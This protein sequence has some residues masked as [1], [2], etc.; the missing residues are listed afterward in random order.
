MTFVFIICLQYDSSSS[1][2]NHKEP[3]NGHSPLFTA[4]VNGKMKF[5]K[6]LLKHGADPNIETNAGY[7][8]IHMAC[9]RKRNDILEV[10]LKYVRDTKDVRT[11]TSDDGANAIHV[12]YN[13]YTIE[14]GEYSCISLII[15]IVSH[16]LFRQLLSI[17][18]INVSKH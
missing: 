10:L 17:H 14:F 13:E 6:L 1:N 2:I 12:Q 3:R 9:V 11:H 16:L 7:T 8:P 18:V 4:V 5:A 15:D